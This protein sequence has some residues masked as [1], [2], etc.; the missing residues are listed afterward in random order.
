MD[1]REISSDD[2]QIARQKLRILRQQEIAA[3]LARMGQAEQARQARTKL[4]V[5]L[6]QLDLMEERAVV[7]PSQD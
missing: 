5:M 6:D 1:A 4:L 7:P 3:E 2:Q